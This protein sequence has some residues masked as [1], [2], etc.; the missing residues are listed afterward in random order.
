ML[1]TGLVVFLAAHSVRIFAENW[2]THMR[3]MLGENAF[4]GAFSVVSLIGLGLIIWGFGLAREQPIYLWSPPVGMRHAA[5]DEALSHLA[6]VVREALRPQDTL[7][8]YGGE[9]FVVI[10]PDTVLEDGVQALRRLQRE[11]TA[12]LFLSGQDKILITFSAGVAQLGTEETGL[13]ALKRADLAMYQAKRAGKNR[14]VG[15]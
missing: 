15:I 5:G 4:N 10:L 2:R 12:R 6:Q 1:L 11:L 7:A 3:E 13:Q 14:V 9:E 8:R